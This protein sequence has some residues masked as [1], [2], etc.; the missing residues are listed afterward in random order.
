VEAI[1]VQATG[2]QGV[3]EFA[4]LDAGDY[5][6]DG[7]KDGY[8]SVCE[9]P[10][11]QSPGLPMVVSAA[12]LEVAL[13]MYPIYLAVYGV[14]NA[15]NLG[16]REFAGL[17]VSLIRSSPGTE[18]P[19][20][21]A[22][23]V[24]SEIREKAMRL[25]VAYPLS[26]M[27]VMHAP[28]QPAF[29]KVDLFVCGHKCDSYEVQLK[30]LAEALANL[31]PEILPVRG[32][33]DVSD[34]EVDCPV[35]LELSLG[36][37]SATAIPIS[38]GVTRLRLPHGRYQ[39]HPSTLRSFLRRGE[40]ERSVIVPEEQRIVVS[41]GKEFA[42]LELRKSEYWKDEVLYLAGGDNQVVLWPHGGFPQ[43]FYMSPGQYRLTLRAGV[44]GKASWDQ[45]VEVVNGERAT[46]SVGAR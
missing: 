1:S 34:L 14:T 44:E 40:W 8:L 38:P 36:R 37:A 20:Y 2:S 17:T 31:A 25:G 5:V 9:G 6:I 41:P 27:R 29:V 26:K 30:P 12:G 45:V 4:D 11:S 43:L 42:T 15:T 19:P 18:V 28:D 10:N 33:W 46:V 22:N 7:D 39:M 35:P 13:V 16:E 3:F 24:E 32:R 21:Y 23:K